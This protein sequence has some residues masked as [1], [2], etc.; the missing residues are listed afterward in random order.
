MSLFERGSEAM[1]IPTVAREVYD[2]SGAGD[3]VIATMSLAMS[4]GASLKDAA[5]L[6]N[7]AAG[8]KVGKLGIATVS[9]AE[10]RHYLDNR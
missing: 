1:H 10:L 4:S 7:Y 2:V 9:N 6:A 5:V 8:I 3:T